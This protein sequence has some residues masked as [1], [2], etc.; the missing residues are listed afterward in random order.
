MDHAGDQLLPAAFLFPCTHTFGSIDQRN[1]SETHR[2]RLSDS[3]YFPSLSWVI[4]A[5][6]L[7]NLLQTNGA[8]N[9]LL[10]VPGMERINFLGSTSLIALYFMPPISGRPWDMVLFST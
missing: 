4:V 6:I 3:I 7:K 2:A 10:T 5:G 1:A 9:E 8:V